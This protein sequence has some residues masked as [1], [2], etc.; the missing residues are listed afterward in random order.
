M[1]VTD[2]VVFL[3]VFLI[4]TIIPH[5]LVEYEKLGAARL[6]GYPPSQ[7][8]KAEELEGSTYIQQESPGNEYRKYFLVF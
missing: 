6:V 4:K 5:A 3:W 1:I 2:F 8:H 7:D